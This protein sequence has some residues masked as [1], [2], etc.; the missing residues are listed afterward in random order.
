[1]EPAD[2]DP[3][4][5]PERTRLAWRRTTLTCVAVA[6]L[7]GRLALHARP[8]APGAVVMVAVVLAL[9]VGVFIEL[10]HRRARMMHAARPAAIS[11]RWVIA[12]AGCAVAIA[13]FGA[14]LVI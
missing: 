13:V 1:M 5:Q 9:A 7:A 8:S 3:A 4:A 12:A 6:L 11:P 10:A 14:V 2:R